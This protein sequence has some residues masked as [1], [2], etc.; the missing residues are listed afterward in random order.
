MPRYYFHL[1]DQ[2]GRSADDEG[3]DY[4]DLEHAYLEA[5]NTALEMSFEM[6]RL[7][8]DPHRHRFEIADA[9]GG[10]L[11]DLTFNEVLRP[12]GMDLPAAGVSI[13]GR[14]RR[15]SDRGRRLA[16]ELALEVQAAR[17]TLKETRAVLERSRA[18]D[19][20]QRQR[21]AA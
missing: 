12:T 6:L 9:Q 21:N 20:S 5:W 18:Q 2:H 16:G 3:A 1:I 14:T 8:A 13:Q 17:Q 4:P 10:V 11:A 19:A 7:R 15:E